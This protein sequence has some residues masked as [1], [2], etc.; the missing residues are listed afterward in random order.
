VTWFDNTGWHQI[1]I[2][3]AQWDGPTKAITLTLHEAPA[4]DVV[5]IIARGAGDA[6]LLGANLA[7]LAGAISDPP[8]SPSAGRDFVY[9]HKRS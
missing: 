6:P 8:T 5:R 7:P 4:G 3:N 1:A 9:M 2:D